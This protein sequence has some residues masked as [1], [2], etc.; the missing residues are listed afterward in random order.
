MDRKKRWVIRRELIGFVLLTALLLGGVL[1]SF[2][3]EQHH[4]TM[5]RELDSAAWYALQQNWDKAWETTEG[6]SQRWQEKWNFCA[7]FAD[8][9]PMEDIDAQFAQLRV[10][11]SARAAQEYAAV[12]SALAQNLQAMANAHEL[13]WWNVL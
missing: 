5:A 9:S 1:S 7:A 3:L 8:H 6:V 2:W 10:Y 11:A 13:R 12:C 4:R